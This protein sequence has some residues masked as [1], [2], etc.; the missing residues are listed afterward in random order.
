M[1]YAFRR[2]ET[3]MIHQADMLRYII[4]L[5]PM[6]QSSLVPTFKSGSSASTECF[7]PRG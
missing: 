4:I 1:K 5:Q 7:E 3:F 2:F 6:G